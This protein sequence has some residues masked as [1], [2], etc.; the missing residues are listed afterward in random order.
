MALVE[1][2]FLKIWSQIY[3]MELRVSSIHGMLLKR[4]SDM[5]IIFAVLMILSGLVV[6]EEREVLRVF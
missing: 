6:E 4:F 1:M 5:K 2:I 3:G